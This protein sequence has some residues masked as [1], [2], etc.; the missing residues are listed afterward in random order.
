MSLVCTNSNYLFWTFSMDLRCDKHTNRAFYSWGW[1]EEVIYSEEG[2]ILFIELW[3][4][5]GGHSIRG[6]CHSLN[7]YHNI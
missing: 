2:V 7:T 3:A 6:R 5:G 4:G 1:E